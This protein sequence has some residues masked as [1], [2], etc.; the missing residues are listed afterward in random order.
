MLNIRT[1]AVIFIIIFVFLSSTGCVENSIDGTIDILVTILPQKEMLEAIGGSYITVTLMVPPGQSP[2]S[3]EPTPEQMTKVAKAKAYFIVGS[4]VEFEITHLDTILTQNPDLQIYDCSTYAEVV[5]FD[6]HYGQQYYHNGSIQDH[7]A[8]TDPHIWT[9]PLNFKKMAD[10]VFEGLIDIDPDHQE[11]YYGNYQEYI[12]QLDDLH[13]NI[14]LILSEFTGRSFMVYHPAWGYFGDTYSLEQIAIEE[15]G[16]QPGPAGVAALIQQAKDL[17]ISVIFVSPQFDMSNA[18]TIA[19]EIDGTVIPI[20]P[21]MGDYEETLLKLA[22]DMV[23]GF[24]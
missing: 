9:S 1:F 10:I 6:E 21:L 24:K 13:V 5:S 22:T 18:E 20:D 16:K 7:E 19:S 23:K 12:S 3:F 14:G 15:E 8:G 11:Y 4:G 17:E 2:H